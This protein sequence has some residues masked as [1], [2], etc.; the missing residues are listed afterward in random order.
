MS[1]VMIGKPGL[2]EDST[3][4]TTWTSA[5]MMVQPEQHGTHSAYDC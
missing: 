2:S 4:D 5:A 1:S 3:A